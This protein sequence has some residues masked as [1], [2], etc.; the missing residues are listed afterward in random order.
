M[1][2]RIIC[3]LLAGA[4]LLCTAGCASGEPAVQTQSE[5]A[6]APQTNAN[7][8]DII[9]TSVDLMQSIAPVREEKQPISPEAAAAASDFALRLTQAANDPDKNT[10]ISPLSV[11]CALAMTANGAGDETLLQMENTLGMRR[12]QYNAFFLSYLSALRSALLWR[13][14]LSC[15]L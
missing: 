7:A 6:E 1:K 11:L 10:L 15:A 8:P 2:T 14:R 9:N 5:S 12:E 3:F 4:L 13:G